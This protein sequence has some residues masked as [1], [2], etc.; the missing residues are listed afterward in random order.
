MEIRED[1]EKVSQEV[2]ARA[3]VKDVK[4]RK[5]TIQREPVV[6]R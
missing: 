3:D 2:R 1:R 6:L 5:L 4:E